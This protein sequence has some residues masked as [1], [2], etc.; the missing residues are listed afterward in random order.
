MA[1]SIGSKSLQIEPQNTALPIGG[2]HVSQ[3]IHPGSGH[4]IL[5]ESLASETVA[6]F[7]LAHW[8]IT[9]PKKSLRKFCQ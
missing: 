5:K 9:A 1:A 8:L 2:I 6:N 4:S 7:P 3:H